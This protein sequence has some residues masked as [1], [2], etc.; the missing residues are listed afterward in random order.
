MVLRRDENWSNV[1]VAGS[2]LVLMAYGGYALVG[3]DISAYWLGYL[4]KAYQQTGSTW[5]ATL[6]AYEKLVSSHIYLIIGVSLTLVMLTAVSNLLL[7]RWLQSRMYHPGGLKQ[8][9]LSIELN[10]AGLGLLIVAAIVWPINHS[11]GSAILPAAMLP[12]L[13]A[14]VSIAH[15][16]LLRLK[17]RWFYLLV[18]YVL[19]I[20]SFVMM[21]IILI[22]L[23]VVDRW[24]HWQRPLPRLAEEV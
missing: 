2:L 17:R 23:A 9:L 7:A 18:F 11:V 14:G 3:G 21:S 15:V 20:F 12:A 19:M 24:Y 16:L 8:E 22:S 6:P 1:F 10:L 5:A 13:M 4:A